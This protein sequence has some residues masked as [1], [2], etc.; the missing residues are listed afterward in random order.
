MI[1]WLMRMTCWIPK[2][3]NAHTGCVILHCNNGC[4]NAL[5]CYDI[6]ILSVLFLFTAG[7]RSALNVRNGSPRKAT[8]PEISC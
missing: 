7:H 3:G 8:P 4:T 2:A 1:I 6:H 5:Q